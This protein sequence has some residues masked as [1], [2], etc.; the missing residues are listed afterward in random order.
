[1]DGSSVV[2]GYIIKHQEFSFKETTRSIGFLQLPLSEGIVNKDYGLVGVLV[3]ADAL[4]LLPVMYALGMGSYDEPIVKVLQ[5]MGCSTYSV[6]L[7]FKVN[8]P[9]GFFRNIQALRKSKLRRLLMDA[10]AMSGLG[11]AGIK[12][13]QNLYTKKRFGN[14]TIVAEQ[15]DRF[16]DWSNEL[17]H[18]CKGEY[19]MIAVRDSVTLNILYPKEKPRFIRLKVLEGNKTIGWSVVLD[20]QMRNHNYFANIRVG[21]IVDCLAL[22]ENAAS[23]IRTATKYLEAR[24]VDLILSNQA[25][26]SWCLALKESGYVRGPSNYILATSKKLTEF[27]DPFDANKTDIHINRG[28]GDGPIHL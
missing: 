13:L 9:W 3:L 7:Y 14:T 25:N 28:D 21:S 5:A 27:L 2:G 8:H 17:W 18:R 4:R 20:S 12:I 16:S 15:V 1:M 26:R 10:M 24:G 22:P 6:P 19:A 23:V 11:W